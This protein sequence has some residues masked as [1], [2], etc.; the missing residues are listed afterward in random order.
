M[1]RRRSVVWNF[2]CQQIEY[3]LKISKN[4]KPVYIEKCS[5]LEFDLIS[6]CL[7]LF[8]ISILHQVLTMKEIVMHNM[9][10]FL[11]PY[12]QGLTNCKK[13][14]EI[15]NLLTENCATEVFFLCQS[16]HQCFWSFLEIPYETTFSS[17]FHTHLLFRYSS[18]KSHLP[19][20]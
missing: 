19:V 12:E 1:V 10:S 5:H 9:N 8:I 3:L 15:F 11:S 17:L 14:N 13:N 4:N 16:Q 2:F 18:Q 20:W 7:V 6:F